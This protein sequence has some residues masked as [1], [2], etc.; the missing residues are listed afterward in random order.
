MNTGFLM[1]TEFFCWWRESCWFLCGLAGLA[2][3]QLSEVLINLCGE[4]Y[5]ICDY[6]THVLT[7]LIL[8]KEIMRKIGQVLMLIPLE[9]TSL[10][11]SNFTS[12]NVNNWYFPIFLTLNIRF[13]PNNLKWNERASRALVLWYISLILEDGSQLHLQSDLLLEDMMS[14]I[15]LSINFL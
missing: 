5:Q 3:G 10:E 6:I 14:L 12:C 4:L 2:G 1:T 13:L 9:F 7:K 15:F 8:N 11:L